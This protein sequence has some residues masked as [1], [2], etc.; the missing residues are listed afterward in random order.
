MQKFDLVDALTELNEDAVLEEV[1]AQLDAGVPAMEIL[2]QL[3][4][5]MELVGERY[6]A[7][8]YFLAEMIMS[9]DI[10]SSAAA[11]MEAFFTSA[12]EA[13][14]GGTMVVGTV[15]DDIHDIGKNIVAAILSCNGVKVVD[16][17]VDVGKEAFVRAVA[18][19]K[20]EFV[21]LCCLLTTAFDAMRETAAAVRA[22]DPSVKILIGGGP[23]DEKVAKYCGA[24]EYCKNAYAAVAVTCKRCV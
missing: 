3:Q 17:G 21:G 12:R 6:E 11:L 7:G 19:Y 10:F 5:G 1:K 24:D 20:P 15:K 9:A 18:A 22:A 14:T 23:V 13:R 4:Q 8:D 16:L 2:V